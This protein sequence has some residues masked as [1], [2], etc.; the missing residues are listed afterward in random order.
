MHVVAVGRWKCR[1]FK[2]MS[3]R[4]RG[5]FSIQARA[6]NTSAQSNALSNEDDVVK[7][8]R[9]YTLS[10]LP[11]QEAINSRTLFHAVMRGGWV[12]EV[13]GLGVQSQHRRASTQPP[14]PPAPWRTVTAPSHADEVRWNARRAS[15]RRTTT[16]IRH[17]GVVAT[18]SVRR[19]PPLREGREGVVRARGAL[20]GR[21]SVLFLRS[22]FAV[23]MTV[24]I[25][26]AVMAVIPRVLQSLPHGGSA[27]STRA[28]QT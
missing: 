20:E 7:R 3:L 4:L 16:Y 19:A 22:L 6:C 24:V 18:T 23:L 14:P 5:G 17:I 21:V 2:Y 15:Q 8:S 26:V 11:Q 13:G 12:E 27:R 9:Q 25:I 1:L 28:C 10:P